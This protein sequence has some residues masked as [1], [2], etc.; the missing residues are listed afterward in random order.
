MSNITIKFNP[1]KRLK[2]TQQQIFYDNSR[3][4]VIAAGRRY[5]KSYLS[6]YIILTKALSKPNQNLFFV[7]PTFSQARQ[8][9]WEILKDKVRKQLAQKINESRLEVELINGSRIFLKGADR[10]DTMRGVS[11]DGCVL[12]EFATVRESALVWQEVLRPA[13][14]DKKGWC[15]F[16]SSPKGREYFYDLYNNAK[17]S[18]D[19]NSWQFTTLQG[20]YVDEDEILNA[21]N[22]LDDRSFR[23][24]YEASFETYDGLVVPDYDRAL[25]NTTETIQ[26]HETLIIGIDFNVNKMP[27][28][29]FVKRGNELHCIDF[30][31]GSFNT[32]TLVQTLEIKYP[33]R[34]I[35]F[36]TDASGTQNKSSA[37]GMTDIKIIKKIGDVHNLS[38]NPNI[39]DRVNAFNSMVK[40]VDGSRKIFFSNKIKR[41]V[42]TLEKHEFD[43]SGLPNKKHEYFD[44]VF[45]SLSY[46]A[47]HY[48]DY[49]K[50]VYAH[51]KRTTY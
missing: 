9:L 13:L 19:W 30:L 28:A 34:K 45:D 41:I 40:A 39:I 36:H 23:Q 42:Q 49:G 7:A 33:N 31:F 20:G 51:S 1:E 22:D 27:C 37:A 5:G 44:D 25:N 18:D 26:E 46:V 35:M 48:S 50:S 3:F 17:T 38:K 10:S 12:D 43:E 15:I 29:I 6:T 47:W 14:S 11:L 32:T 4:K 8:I 2:E 16:I 21:R 24:E